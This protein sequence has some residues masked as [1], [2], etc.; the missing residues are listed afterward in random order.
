M[1]NI[2]V[3]KLKYWDD[4]GII[5]AVDPHAKSRQFNMSDIKKIILI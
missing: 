2:L 3:I 4:N 1:T 5:K